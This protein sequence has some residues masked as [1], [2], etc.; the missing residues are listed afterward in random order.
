MKKVLLS[1][2]IGLLCLVGKSQDST[3][4][5]W[6]PVHKD[7]IVEFKAIINA[8]RAD[9]TVVTDWLAFIEIVMKEQTKKI[10][11]PKKNSTEK[12]PAIVP[13]ATDSTKQEPVNPK[14]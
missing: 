8:S 14:P 13:P 5:Y 11:I 6:F 4:F 10:P 7:K 1:L 3:G 2:G 12:P 9:H